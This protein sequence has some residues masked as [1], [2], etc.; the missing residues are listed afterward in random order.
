MAS[1]LYA[2]AKKH[3]LSG[4]LDVENGDIRALLI[5]TAEYTVNLSTHDMLEDIAAGGRVGTAVA[6]TTKTVTAGVFDA[7][8]VTFNA[9]SGDDVGAV[10]LYLHTGVESTSKLLA[11]I[12][13]AS[14]LPLTPS[15]ADVVLRWSAG[16]NKIFALT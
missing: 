12:D 15:G 1:G 16:A 13:T 9:V 6:L 11:Y 8:D 10:V 3:I 4:D 5:D 2:I 14:G 7:D